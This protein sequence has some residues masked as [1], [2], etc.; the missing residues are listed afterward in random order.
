[1]GSELDLLVLGNSVLKKEEQ[2]PELKIVYKDK[3]EMD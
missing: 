3:F 1:M 2:D